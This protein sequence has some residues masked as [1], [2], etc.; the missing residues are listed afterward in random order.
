MANGRARKG[1]LRPLLLPD[2]TP[3]GDCVS[4]LSRPLFLLRW[5]PAEREKVV[6]VQGTRTVAIE[7]PLV[8][9]VSSTCSS[10]LFSTF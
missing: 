4:V 5:K 1:P 6:V 10:R 8:G 7:V 9:A 2:Q 3:N